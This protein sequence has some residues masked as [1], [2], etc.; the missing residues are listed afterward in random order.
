FLSSGEQ[1][2]SPPLRGV[3]SS[4]NS[5]NDDSVSD[6]ALDFSPRSGGRSPEEAVSPLSSAGAPPEGRSSGG[7]SSPGSRVQAAQAV[8]VVEQA[9]LRGSDIYPS[10][11]TMPGPAEFTKADDC[12][13]PLAVRALALAFV[14]WAASDSSF[15]AQFVEDEL[16]P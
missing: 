6:A 10:S 13:S 3:L 12:S 11:S 16:V 9:L 15:G 2:S 1:V 14:T 8:Q 5:R 7:P 4:R